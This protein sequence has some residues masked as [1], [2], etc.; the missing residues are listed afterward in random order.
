MYIQESQVNHVQSGKILLAYYSVPDQMK[1]NY[2]NPYLNFY[3]KI[4]QIFSEIHRLWS[5]KDC[6]KV[7]GVYLGIVLLSMA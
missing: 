5:M 4:K 3:L 2:G 1:L 7:N 6:Y